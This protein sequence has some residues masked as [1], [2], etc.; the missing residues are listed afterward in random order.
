MVTVPGILL[1][2]LSPEF[3]FDYGVAQGPDY[4]FGQS[5]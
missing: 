3:R 5:V 1:E 4:A 2:L